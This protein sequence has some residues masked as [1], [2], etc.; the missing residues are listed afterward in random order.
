MTG[1]PTQILTFDAKDRIA[2]HA[3]DNNGN[4]TN[5][6]GSGYTYDFENRLTGDGNATVVY[7][8]GS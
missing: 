2:I 6:D 3:Y 7:V 1:G 4:T 5:A 8:K